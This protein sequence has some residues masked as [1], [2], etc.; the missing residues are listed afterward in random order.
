MVEVFFIIFFPCYPP[1][2][3]CF[4]S[5]STSFAVYRWLHKWIFFT[6]RSTTPYLF[7]LYF[8]SHLYV[9]L[10]YNTD[11]WLS[12]RTND[13]K[14]KLSLILQIQNQ[15]EFLLNVNYLRVN[16]LTIVRHIG[17]LSVYFHC[18]TVVWPPI[19]KWCLRLGQSL[20]IVPLGPSNVTENGEGKLGSRKVRV[21]NLPIK[22]L[23]QRKFFRLERYYSI[24]IFTHSSIFSV[25]MS[26]RT[27]TSVLLSPPTKADSSTGR[28]WSLEALIV[29]ACSP[30]CV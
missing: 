16:Y 29:Q 11:I 2:D 26:I 15:E 17:S 18:L 13:Y 22:A 21:W 12:F 14:L 1:Q 7:L 24:T 20:W 4:Y 27:Y 8:F 28:P 30:W 5:I 6:L 23:Y 10:Y 9:A 19:Y 25:K 3:G